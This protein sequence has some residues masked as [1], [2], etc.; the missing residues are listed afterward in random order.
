MYFPSLQN[1]FYYITKCICLH[2]KMYFPKLQSVFSI[3]CEI[4]SVGH[5]TLAVPVEGEVDGALQG[6]NLGHA[7]QPPTLV[8]QAA[9]GD[10]SLPDHREATGPH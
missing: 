1:V 5:L 4:A 3:I 10:H 7:G 2:F 6:G 8:P 9:Q